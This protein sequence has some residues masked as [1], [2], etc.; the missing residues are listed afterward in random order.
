MRIDSIE[1]ILE[2]VVAL[3]Q[4]GNND[5]AERLLREILETQPEYSPALR[6]L[7]I[8]EHRLGHNKLAIESLGKALSI[9]PGDCIAY[10]A[11]GQAFRAL[12]N[13]Q[14]AEMDLRH[15]LSIE[16]RRHDAH[17]N[18]AW[19]LLEAGDPVR[20]GVFFKNVLAL[21]GESFDASNCLGRISY[22]SGQFI[23][24]ARY[25]RDA[26]KMRPGLA[27]TRVRLCHSL[28]SAGQTV[29]AL[30][31]AQ[32]GL[33][34]QADSVDL[35]IFA[36]RVAFELAD[37]R[38]AVLH[39]EFVIKRDTLHGAFAG[40]SA[41]LGRSRYI[42]QWC[43]EKQM[44]IVR[45]ANMQRHKVR[46]CKLLPHGGPAIEMPDPRTP[47]VYV[48]RLNGCRLLPCE[49]LLRMG[50]G[51][52]FFDDVLSKPLHRP[53]TN[54][55]V[56][57][58]ADDGRLLMT[59]P[60]GEFN[61]DSACA[62]LGAAKGYFAWLFECVTRLW[63][64]KQRAEWA[65]LPLLVHTG[66]SRYQNE[67][68]DLLGYAGDRLI[69]IPDSATATCADLHV[70]SLSAPF[71]FVAPF[72]IEHLRRELRKAIN[73][74]TDAPKRL[75]LSRQKLQHRKLSDYSDLESLLLR[76]G[77]VILHPQ[78]VSTYEILQQILTAEVIIG[79]EGAAMSNVF[80]AP[81]KAIIGLITA[82]ER[83]ALRYA[84]P[85]MVLGHE[86]TFL[87]GEP[88]YESNQKITECD[89]RLRPDILE[90]YL[91]SL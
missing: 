87:L 68:L 2:Q 43:D 7:G 41:A 90:E 6:F 33:D 38:R 91:K 31:V 58:L 29:E 16:P 57:H 86:F 69:Q 71:N 1:V 83:T 66:L 63:A 35:S 65:S 81:A 20:A 46:N 45:V 72:T 78:S 79:L 19:T 14:A 51:A 10:V 18:L 53:F 85:S 55:H 64:Y 59:E 77:F 52:V 42:K 17:L 8:A 88:E 12:G 25:F 47:E 3:L 73:V 26:L 21:L 28:F 60:E 50:D 9:D 82:T 76:F 84:S 23:E 22:D 11:R 89:I 34:L 15:A 44:E 37:E 4:S 67:M 27:D 5:Q 70:A 48:A 36:A 80:F 49:H 74:R 39:L 62:Y 24:S 30:R 56:V 75:F 32:E 54:T 61:L 13:L 40:S